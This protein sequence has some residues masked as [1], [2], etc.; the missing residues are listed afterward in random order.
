MSVVMRLGLRVLV[1]ILMLGLWP[2]VAWGQLDKPLNA[3]A[4]PGLGQPGS[5]GHLPS[6]GGASEGIALEGAPGRKS[7]APHA[8]LLY[9]SAG[10]LGESGVGWQ[11]EFGRIERSSREGSPALSLS[12]KFVFHLAGASAE[13]IPIG[14]G[15]YRARLEGIYRRYTRVGDHW[16]VRDASG[17]VYLFG[18]SG[19]TRID[20]QL[21]MLDRITDPNGN[22]I[23]ISYRVDGGSFYPNVVHYTGYA[24]TGDL[25]PNE[26]RFD[27]D[28]RDDQRISYLFGVEQR[29]SLRLSRAS[30]FAEG[31]LVRRYKITYDV[32]PSNQRSL[33][34]AIDLVTSD[35]SSVRS[36]SYS[37]RIQNLGFGVPDGDHHLPYTFY[38]SNG[39]DRG[40][41]T[42]DVNGDTFLDVLDN[43]QNVYL[44]DGHGLFT[45]DAA[46][47]A[48]LVAAG[49][50]FVGSQGLDA[51]TRLIDVNGDQR[52]DLIV[53]TGSARRVL[54]NTGT[55]W[56]PSASYTTSLGSIQE[57]VSAPRDQLG[58]PCFDG[59]VDGG[60]SDGVA[61]ADPPCGE[62]TAYNLGF[63]FVQSSGDS[64]G[65]VPADV[66]GDGLL[67]FV[68]SYET[69]DALFVFEPPD[70]S[71]IPQPPRRATAKVSAVYLNTGDGWQ[72]SPPLSTAL[73]TINP[74]VIN[75][76]LGGYDVLDVN[77]DGLA[78]I[79]NTSAPTAAGD[80]RAVLLGTGTGWVSQSDYTNSLRMTAIVSLDQSKSQGLVPLDFNGDGLID[81]L[82]GDESTK[83]AYRN[84]GLGWVEEPAMSANLVDIGFVSVNGDG[85]PNGFLFGDVDGD[86]ISDVLQ[87]KDGAANPIRYARGPAG[88]LLTHVETGLGETFDLAYQPSSRFDN[89]G[90]D[91]VQQLPFVL[92]VLTSITRSAGRGSPV[93]GTFS[94][95]G[96]LY[97]DRDLRGFARSESTDFHGNRTATRYDQSESLAGQ[98]TSAE[99]SDASALRRRTTVAYQLA[100][101]A[102][103]VTQIRPS[104]TDVETFD[105]GGTV[106]TR[107]RTT[108]DD[109]L[110]VIE[111]SKDGDV[112]VA[113][114]GARTVFTFANGAGVG[115]VNAVTRTRVFDTSGALR[116]ES[117]VFYDSLAEGQIAKGNPTKFVDSSLSSAPPIVRQAA[118]DAF[119]NPVRLTDAAGSVSTI[120]YAYH[121]TFKSRAVDPLGRVRATE[122]DPR[123]GVATRE[124]DPNGQI[125]SRTYDAAARLVRETLPG[126]EASPFGTRTVTYSP[127]GA[128]Q[129]FRIAATEVPGAPGTMDTVGF[130]DGFGRVYRLESEAAGGRTVVVTLEYDDRGEVT[131]SSL[132]FFAGD[133]PPLIVTER[134]VLSRVVRR[135]QPDG[136]VDETHYAGKQREFI[137][138]RGNRTL[139]FDDA[140]GNTLETQQF[141][142]GSTLVTK[143]RF[144]VFGRLIEVIDAVGQS[145]HVT[146]DAFGRRTKL[147]D[148][149]TGT[150]RY[151]YDVSGNLVQQIDAAGRTTEFKYN[152]DGDLIFKKLPTGESISLKYGVARDNAVGR[153]SHVDDAAGKLDIRYDRRG[154]QVE[155]VRTVEGRTFRTRYAYD[156]LGRTTSIEYPDGFKAKYR[157]DT[158]GLV[159]RITD[160]RDEG[161][162]ESIDHNALGRPTTMSFANGVNSGFTYDP[163]GFT[164]T[165]ATADRRGHS[166]QNIAYDYDPEGNVTRITNFD[167]TSFSQTFQY[168][169]IHRLVHAVGGYGDET[170]RYDAGSTLIRKDNLVFQ[171]DPSH[172]QQVTCGIDLDLIKKDHNGIGN[173][174]RLRACATE[175]ASPAGGLAADDRAAV[176]KILSK[177]KKND[178]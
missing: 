86:G 121:A 51:G 126:D 60:P 27:Y 169:E 8:A 138:R 90:A 84:T 111:L 80:N 135:T 123:F 108:Y 100:T 166:L 144:D 21:W 22:T 150:N 10:G 28:P 68:W 24:P 64:S 160:R 146:Y 82:R 139:L 20:G 106:H 15:E 75:T 3:P 127:L 58:L 61:E 104:Q 88:D 7:F 67:D 29:R 118:Y 112:D 12:D 71:L 87:S 54:L 162:V 36:R 23:S 136:T 77:G 92:N 70:G 176:A 115:I 96:G 116:S 97:A 81:Y 156:S 26:I 14:A 140:Q 49:V 32:S 56:S 103:G 153:I 148:P 170:Y 171:R 98:V 159:D 17:N 9:N 44:G 74:F 94:Y 165:I 46:W 128:N 48:S 89:R 35:E 19:A 76:Q 125:I 145:T 164:R 131:Q 47:S 62:L 130:V 2:A 83:I 4:F 161:I 78:D 163:I 13:I 18:N 59:G 143:Q 113:D 50:A 93:G 72:K 16:E 119:G 152:L 39:R 122:T 114:D 85:V 141:V 142:A 129:F 117:A 25:G 55:D 33:V 173:D 57:S 73:G 1:C 42:A 133:A 5:V 168:D 6:V 109:F 31:Q 37:Y 102:A 167:K 120:E 137:D 149:N 52:P 147:E 157:Y 155:R 79:V 38:D 101:P 107:T 172:R 95:A 110:N 34:K 30:F 177:S 53:A 151:A 43:G 105:P 174:P 154:Q 132:P 158:G 99:V 45:R 41:R 178:R 66:N 175:L 11:M 65:V 91:T 124:T 40:G 63:S 134:D 69:T